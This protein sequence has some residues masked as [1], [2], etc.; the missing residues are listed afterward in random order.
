MSDLPQS[1]DTAAA[2]RC[3]F[4]FGEVEDRDRCREGRAVKITT[5]VGCTSAEA[6]KLFGLPD[7][8]PLHS[9]WRLEVEKR[10]AIAADEIGSAPSRR[11]RRTEN[12]KESGWSGLRH[13]PRPQLVP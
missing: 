13:S 2:R 10:K 11:S 7:L 12:E 4:P 9:L 5:R 6:Q 3:N 1:A 8:K